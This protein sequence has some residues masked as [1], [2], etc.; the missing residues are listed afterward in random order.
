M[1]LPI[2]KHIFELLK[3]HD[4]VIITG[5]G[6]FILNPRSA[7]INDIT[8]QIYPPSKEI[9]FN[10]NLC[11]N[12]GLL[13]N[14]LTTEEDISYDE[15]CIEIMK[16]SR[17]AKLKLNNNNSIFFENIGTLQLNNDGH[18]EFVAD[19]SFNFNKEAY[20]LRSFQIAKLA[21]IKSDESR[22][23]VMSAAAVIILLT[24]IS[25]FSL[26][27]NWSNISFLN[28]GPLETNNYTP[29]IMYDKDSLG[30]ESPGIYN[31]QVSKVDP[32]LY[33]I[34]GT[35]YHIVT[36]KCLK[37]GFG[38]DVQIKI[39]KDNKDKIKREL[40]FLNLEETEYSECYK[41]VQVY[42]E[43]SAGSNK[44][45]VML[46][47]GRMKEAVFVFEETY[48]DPYVIANS[49]PEKELKNSQS[50]TLAFKDIPSRFIDAIKSISEPIETNNIKIDNTENTIIEES[51]IE[52]QKKEP[53]IFHIIVGSFSD[54]KNAQAFTKQLKRRGFK[55]AEIIGKNESGL[56]RV[57]TSSFYTQEEAEMELI[58]IK[59][60]LSSAWVLNSNE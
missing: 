9:S 45:M 20:G 34:N 31:V 41:I 2:E 15:A 38:R 23:S 47:N 35:D 32:D 3:H 55:S 6:G 57:A 24:C 58:N 27:N 37:E 11:K 8:N 29:R 5:L 22:F 43:M 14:H 17:K 13:A 7:Y 60:K 1:K 18:I 39:W 56:T 19:K 50:D 44:I 26:N 52:E 16:F 48:I 33:K 28:L 53:K 42:N 25:F 21:Q 36:K 40:C 12:D 4:C 51:I 49:S 10:K 59:L 30:K 54:E 46:K